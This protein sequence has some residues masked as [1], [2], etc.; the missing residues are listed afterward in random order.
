MP[1]LAVSVQADAEEQIVRGGKQGRDEGPGRLHCVHVSPAL[2]ILIYFAVVQ[3]GHVARSD[4]VRCQKEQR[5]ARVNC[6]R[7]DAEAHLRFRSYGDS[8]A[9][10]VGPRLHGIL[11]SEGKEGAGRDP[12]RASHLKSLHEVS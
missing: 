9:A 5:N 3:P 1:V 6:G 4:L 10:H 2:Q 12:F 8:G 7:I 11:I